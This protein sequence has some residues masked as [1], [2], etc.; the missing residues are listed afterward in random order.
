MSSASFAVTTART[1]IVV[2]V[3]SVTASD[4]VRPSQAPHSPRMSRILSRIA[5][6]GAAWSRWK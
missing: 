1:W 6:I 2:G 5:A 3:V 4:Q